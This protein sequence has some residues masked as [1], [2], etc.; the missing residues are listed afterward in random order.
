MSSYLTSSW[1]PAGLTAAR[2]IILVMTMMMIMMSMMM[3][4]MRWRW[5]M[6]SGM[7][8]TLMSVTTNTNATGCLFQIILI[9]KYHN[10]RWSIMI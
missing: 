1:K 8:V 5:W 2:L 6:I 9:K 7:M 3:I 10:G 4:M